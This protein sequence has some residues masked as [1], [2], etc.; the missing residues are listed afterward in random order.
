M[1]NSD[2]SHKYYLAYKKK[3]Y[4][5][6]AVAF[7]F[8]SQSSFWRDSLGWAIQKIKLICILLSVRE[9]AKLRKK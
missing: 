2:A 7:F 1:E 4:Y 9:T 8:N 5:K 6:K 3:R